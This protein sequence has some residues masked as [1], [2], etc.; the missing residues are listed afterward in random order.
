MP[1]TTQL[2]PE[3]LQAIAQQQAKITAE[4][5]K[6]KQLSG[7][8]VD[9]YDQIENSL[10]SISKLINNQLKDQGASAR[11]VS[12]I[13][14]IYNSLNKSNRELQYLNDRFYEGTLK[15]KD[16]SKQLSQLEDK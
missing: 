8:L 1:D 15:T 5:Q 2:T 3:Q 14:S 11:Q 10:D 4:Q 16:I 7:D 6:Q 12:E 13:K 9:A